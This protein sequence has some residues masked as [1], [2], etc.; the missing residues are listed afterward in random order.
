MSQPI[1]QRLESALSGT[2][3]SGRAI[4]SYMLANLHELPF[5]TAADVA[6]KLGFSESSVGRFCRAI[7]YSHFKD[8]KNDLKNDLGEG[9]WLVG[10]RLQEFP[11][12]QPHRPGPAAQLRA[13]SR[14]ADEGL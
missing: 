9:P 1:K 7:G 4:A 5:Q 12:T 10:D 3:A 11:A 6:G 8:L 14:R 2:T 13:G